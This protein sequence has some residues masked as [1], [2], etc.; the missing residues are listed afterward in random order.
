[1]SIILNHLVGFASVYENLVSPRKQTTPLIFEGLSLFHSHELRGA[2]HLF[3]SIPMNRATNQIKQVTPFPF[4]H[5]LKQ[6]LA[7]FLCL[8]VVEGCVLFIYILPTPGPDSGSEQVLSSI[9]VE[10][11][12]QLH[13]SNSAAVGPTLPMYRLAIYHKA[14]KLFTGV[15]FW[16]L[17]KDFLVQFFSYQRQLLCLC[18][19]CTEQHFFRD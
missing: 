16:R 1:M 2:G 4:A 6:K 18:G 14:K 8:H 13:F 7:Q 3:Y 15:S 17:R 12:Y 10:L 11:I 5:V 19:L 9:F